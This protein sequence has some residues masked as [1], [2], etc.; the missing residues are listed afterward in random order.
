[1]VLNLNILSLNISD[2][3]GLSYNLCEA[4]NKLT[5]HYA[6][7]VVATRTF[8]LKPVMANL[9]KQIF[10]G[11]EEEFRRKVRR[12]V[13]NADVIHINE[14]WQIIKSYGLTAKNCRNKKIIYHGHGSIFRRY[15]ESLLKKFTSLFP[16]LKIIVGT[17]DLLAGITR[18]ATWFPSI[19]PIERYRRTYR[20]KRNNSPVIYYSPTGSSTKIM[21]AVISRVTDQLKHEGLNFGLQVITKTLHSTNMK[22][23]SKADI[24]YDE[25]QPSP[26]YGVNAI[27]AGVFELSVICNMNRYARQYMRNRKL[28]CPFHLAS[29]EE[30]L[31]RVLRKLIKNKGYRDR[32]GRANY[33][34][35]LKNHSPG[36]CLKRFFALVE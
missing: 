28:Q 30:Q 32:C 36:V 23:K 5:P 11:N 9:K 6:I 16:H 10:L 13:K 27:E 8:T 35:V 14:K 2:L 33:Q 17:P 29:T 15:S 20:I 34:Y 31:K 22:R 24:Y 4:I 18:K 19:V 7:N 21:K 26:F 3:G 1:M 25:I 12:W